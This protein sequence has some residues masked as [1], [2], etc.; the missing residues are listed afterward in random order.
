LKYLRI[1]LGLIIATLV[2][3]G[4]YTSELVELNKFINPNG[5]I[6]QSLIFN[7]NFTYTAF[8]SVLFIFAILFSLGFY[9]RLVSIV[10]SMLFILFQYA[11]YKMTPYAWNFNTHL[12]FFT[13]IYSLYLFLPKKKEVSS[14]MLASTI[15]YVGTLYFQAGISKVIFGGWEWVSTGNTVSQFSFFIGTSFGKW[16]VS[17]PGFAQLISG[18]SILV[19]ISVL[20]LI[21]IRSLYRQLG[22]FL[23]LFHLGILIVMGISFWHLVFLFPS[24]FVINSRYRES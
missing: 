15:F 23:I 16:L 2:L 14:T 21:F 13:L 5:S 11:H 4:P 19:E 1:S 10:L 7:S 24:M 3:L 8:R 22:V 9:E 6:I 12:N 18:F 17:I 20:P